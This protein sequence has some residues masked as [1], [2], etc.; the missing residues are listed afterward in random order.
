MYV[1]RNSYLLSKIKYI[2]YFVPIDTHFVGHCCVLNKTAGAT[3]ETG[4][5]AIQ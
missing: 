3:K 4:H 1:F 5:N 2:S